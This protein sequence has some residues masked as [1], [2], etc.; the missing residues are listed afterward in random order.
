M[1]LGVRNILTFQKI[2]VGLSHLPFW[3]IFSILKTAIPKHCQQ[4]KEI[5]LESL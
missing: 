3:Y 2:A 4:K 5:L 1:L